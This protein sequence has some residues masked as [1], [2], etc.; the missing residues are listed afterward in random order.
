MHKPKHGTNATQKP[1][2]QERGRETKQRI[3]QAAYELLLDGPLPKMEDLATVAGVSRTTI[4]RHFPSHEALL[5]EVGARYGLVPTAVASAKSLVLDAAAA[6]IL[7]AGLA[8]LTIQ[9]VADRAGVSAMTIYKAFG[10]KN[11][12]LS[13]VFAE[14]GPGVGLDELLPP[15]ALGPCGAALRELTARGLRYST[16]HRTMLRHIFCPAPSMGGVWDLALQAA[17]RTRDAWTP[18]V[19]LWMDQGLLR[20]GPP[21]RTV[22]DLFTLISAA[23]L[24]DDQPIPTEGPAFEALVDDLM[25]RFLHGA[26]AAA[27]A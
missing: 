6:L 15:A 26:A 22:T 4:Y 11:T 10:D 21:H 18:A 3:L 25:A 14:R 12:L 20:P 9:A 8:G 16:R 24:F 2:R 27:A 7:E 5:S 19:S 1:S 13:S 23:A 17:R